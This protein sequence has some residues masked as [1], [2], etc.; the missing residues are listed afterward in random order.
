M[1]ADISGA[2]LDMMT[3]MISLLAERFKQHDARSRF[4]AFWRASFMP[5]TPLLGYSGRLK[6]G[7]EGRPNALRL[8]DC[9]G[10][11]IHQSPDGSGGDTP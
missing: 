4:M 9:A 7:A 5:E 6:D 2:D 1:P 3:G 11:S 8:D 10:G